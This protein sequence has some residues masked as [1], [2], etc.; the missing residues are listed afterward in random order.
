[1]YVNVARRKKRRG[2]VVHFHHYRRL[3]AR[4]LR[5]SYMLSFCSAMYQ[6]I[7]KRVKQQG[8][9]C[10]KR[11][12]VKKSILLTSSEPKIF[13]MKNEVWYWIIKKKMKLPNEK[14]TF[15]YQERFYVQYMTYQSDVGVLLL[16]DFFVVMTRKRQ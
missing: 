13:W 14:K 9:K 5:F 6:W 15:I 7:R 10:T 3:K 2:K 8:I 12:E 1:M 4:C 11:I 16:T